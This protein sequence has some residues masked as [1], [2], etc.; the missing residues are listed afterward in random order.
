VSSRREARLLEQD[1]RERI[2]AVV[3]D[4]VSSGLASAHSGL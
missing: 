4:A 2:S 1:A 3:S